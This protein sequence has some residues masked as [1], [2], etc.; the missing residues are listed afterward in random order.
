MASS[1]PKTLPTGASVADF[2]AAVP[3]AVRRADCLALQQM[4]QAATQEPAVMWGTAIVG[5]GRYCYVYASGQ[6][7]DW[8]IVAYSPRK[9]DLSVYLMPGF[10]GRSDLLQRLGPHKT[11]KTCLYL[12][13][14]AGLDLA[15]LQQLIDDAVAAMAP[16]R[17]HPPYKDSPP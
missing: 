11:G 5:F 6:S 1:S 4:M 3:D 17:I 13:R 7:G 14:L 16:Q 10:E 2:L 8:P 15:V 12:K 9:G